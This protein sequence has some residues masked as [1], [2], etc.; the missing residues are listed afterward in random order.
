MDD[1]VD[2]F[3]HGGQS[4]SGFRAQSFCVS[5]W[6]RVLKDDVAHGLVAEV[7]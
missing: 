7:F 5:R 3:A 2:G 6:V 4:A 1:V